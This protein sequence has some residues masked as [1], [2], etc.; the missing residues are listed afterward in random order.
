MSEFVEI[1]TE[2]GPL[3]GRSWRAAT[4]TAARTAVVAPPHPLYGGSL[5]NPVVASLVGGLRDAGCDVL[6]FNWR[7]VGRSAGE[8]SGEFADAVADYRAAADAAAANGSPASVAAGYSFGAL[9][10]VAVAAA[11]GAVDRL[12]LVAPPAGMLERAG[13]TNAGVPALVVCGDADEFSP[14]FA[15]RELE[16]SHSGVRL[17]VVKGADHFFSTGSLDRVWGS[18][19][20][21]LAA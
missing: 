6:G 15:L 16:R 1:P 7:G 12:V 5:D 3:E 10:A 20:A 14:E 2:A 18:V 17:E 13:I 21:F 11:G 9:A 19:S 4:N 8:R